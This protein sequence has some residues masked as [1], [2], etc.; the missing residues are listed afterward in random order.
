MRCCTAKAYE[1]WVESHLARTGIDSDEHIVSSRVKTVLRL[2]V[3]LR[4]LFSMTVVDEVTKAEEQVGGNFPEA[5]SQ[6]PAS[7]HRNFDLLQQ[8][9]KRTVNERSGAQ[10]TLWET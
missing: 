8:S 9:W 6:R 1:Y 4:N 2:L 7:R 3:L 10:I 5:T